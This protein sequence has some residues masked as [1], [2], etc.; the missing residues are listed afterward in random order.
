MNSKA[1]DELNE[2]K[3]NTYC[4][5]PL[6]TVA[7]KECTVPSSSSASKII[8]VSISTSEFR[9]HTFTALGSSAA[10]GPQPWGHLHGHF[11]CPRFFAGVLFDDGDDKNTEIGILPA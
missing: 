4:N 8:R 2:K 6:A 1:R 7:E 5:T 3:S 9:D 11:R 10:T